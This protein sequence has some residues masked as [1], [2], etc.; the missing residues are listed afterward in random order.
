MAR[1]AP[2]SLLGERASASATAATSWA[3]EDRF[4]KVIDNGRE[5][6]KCGPSSLGRRSYRKRWASGRN[7]ANAGLGRWVG[8]CVA[9]IAALSP[10]NAK[11]DRC[12]GRLAQGALSEASCAAGSE[13]A[14]APERGPDA[15]LSRRRPASARSRGRHRAPNDGAPRRAAVPWLGAR[16][17]AAPVRSLMPRCL[18]RRREPTDG[19]GGPHNPGVAFRAAPPCPFARRLALPARERP[20]NEN[21]GHIPIARSAANGALCA[22]EAQSLRRRC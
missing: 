14:A 9:E 7:S 2:G 5:I 20:G 13:E 1:D 8:G 15:G 19:E 6:H 3:G 12:I 18:A 10:V 21:E 11:R 17:A 4:R 16:D 22:V